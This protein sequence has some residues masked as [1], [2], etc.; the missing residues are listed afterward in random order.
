MKENLKNQIIS[1]L[2]NA[3]VGSQEQLQINIVVTKIDAKQEEVLITYEKQLDQEPTTILKKQ[4]KNGYAWT[5]GLVMTLAKIKWFN[6]NIII[7][8]EKLPY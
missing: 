2:A 6:T 3:I 7:I 4:T 1:E 5:A 8:N